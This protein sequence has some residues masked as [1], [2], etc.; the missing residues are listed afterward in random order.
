MFQ[1]HTNGTASEAVFSYILEAVALIA[2]HG[3]RLLPDYTFEPDTGL[4]RHREWRRSRTASLHEITY[5]AGRMEYPSRHF[6]EPVSAL[7]GYLEEGR[8]LLERGADVSVAP[9]APLDFEA[10]RWF[11]L[12]CEAASR[13]RGDVPA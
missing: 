10:L 1:S 2:E 9:T 12:P 4:W 13:L 5:A 8:K 7:K 3:W 11:P 6:T